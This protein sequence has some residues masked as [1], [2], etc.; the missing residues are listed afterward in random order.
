VDRRDIAFAHKRRTVGHDALAC[1]A[2]EDGRDSRH[3]LN[4]VFDLTDTLLQAACE[5]DQQA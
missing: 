3:V 1:D 2:D 4:L 5:R